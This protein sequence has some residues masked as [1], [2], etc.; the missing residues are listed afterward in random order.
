MWMG[1]FDEGE[2]WLRRATETLQSDAAPAIGLAMHLVA[3]ML[4]A[5]RGLN[6]EALEELTIAENMQ[7][8][9]TGTHRVTSQ[10]TG[11]LAATQARL[12]MVEAARASLESTTADRANWGEI[13]NA[14]AVI[15]LAESC[16]KHAL[17]A[18]QAVLARTAPVIHDFTVVE[19]HLLAARAHL[20]LGD[21]RAA[22]DATE[23][24]LALAEADRLVLPFAMT[25][26]GD[27]LQTIHRHETT[28]AALLIDI[29]DVLHG[30]VLHGAPVPTEDVPPSPPTERLSPSELRVLRYLPT[31]LSRPQIAGELSVSVNTVNTQLRSIYSKL[32][33]G[34]RSSAV[35]RAREL[36]LLS[37][38]IR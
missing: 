21:H 20:E 24:A 26:S 37:S 19:A 8:R 13:C 22:R 4:P 6:Y 36:R 34:D 28:H 9:L 17:V 23:S 10:I 27:L 15:H 25:A 3:G 33:A 12:G 14:W 38:G 7:S 35:Q 1:E 32:Q 29:L 30:D 16:P 31:N 18:V 2:R 11:W 5:A